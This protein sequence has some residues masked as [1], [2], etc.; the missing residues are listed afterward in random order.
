MKVIR[1]VSFDTSFLLKDDPEVDKIIKGLK[2]DG[3][4]CFVTSTVISELEQ[5]KTWGRIDE[6]AYKKAM[7]RLK[8]VDAKI[9]DFKNRFLSS[10][11]GSQCIASMKT[12][13]GAEPKDIKNDCSILITGLKNGVD[14]FLSEDFHF[15]SSLTE[16]V[17]E[18]VTN[19]ACLEYHQMCGEEL[20]SVNTENFLKVYKEGKID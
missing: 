1:S 18:E 20:Y 2:R 16:E 13:L 12:H 8:R 6:H 14:L 17:L 19:K 10:E 9:I 15:T 7:S 11:I 4:D 5:L 3:I